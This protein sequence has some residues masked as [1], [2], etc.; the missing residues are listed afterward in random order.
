M[1]KN[2]LLIVDDDAA[3]CAQ[4]RWGL[5][6]DY[7]VVLAT[8]RASAAQVFEKHK[9]LVVLLDLGLPPRPDVPDEGFA[10]LA[11][12][13]ARNSPAKVLIISGK[14]DCNNALEAIGQGAYDFLNKPVS[15]AELKVILRRTFH[16]ANLDKEYRELHH[17]LTAQSFEGLLGTSRPMQ[18]VLSSIQKVAGSEEPVLI[19]GE[20]GTGKEVVASVIHRRSARSAGPFVAINCAAIPA[21]LLESE[22]FGH[23]KGAFTGA[24]VQRSGRIETAAGG[25]LFLDEIGELPPMLQ[26]KLLRFL[27]HR[28]IERVGGRKEIHV[29]TRVIAATNADLRR[30]MGTGQ[31]REDLYYRLAVVVIELPPLRARENDALLL[32][33]EFLR[34]NAEKHRKP[35][36]V[37][38]QQARR[39]IQE[40]SWPGNVRELENRV[41]RA[42]VMAENKYVTPA[43]LELT[44]QT[45]PPSSDTNLRLASKTLAR[46]LIAKVLRKHAGKIAPS[47]LE[48]NVS[49]PTLYK[50]INDLGIP[51]EPDAS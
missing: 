12:I 42:V 15:L 39:A 2:V 10:V 51:R 43:D 7:E 49:R 25:T 23:E 21:A 40:Y 29:N 24:H 3:V 34:A 17:Q 48:L 44:G 45:R 38:N 13:F 16:V 20:S 14:E 41:K 30:A 36:L 5:G 4:L 22:L 9:P 46:E 26:V 11:D 47:A 31:I 8:D 1:T 6:Q 18:R 28:R 19:L 33:Q 27:Q 32:A 35:G 37:L 50:L